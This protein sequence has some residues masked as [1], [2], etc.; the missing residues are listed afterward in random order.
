MTEITEFVTDLPKQSLQTL[1][2]YF[3]GQGGGKKTLALAVSNVLLYAESF[4]PDDF[5]APMH[6]AG[7]DSPLRYE[8]LATTL[9]HALAMHASTDD[10]VSRLVDWKSLIKSLLPTLLPLIIGLL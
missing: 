10:A 8:V 4:I 5:P 9:E 2:A 1:L 7:I 3:K 6:A